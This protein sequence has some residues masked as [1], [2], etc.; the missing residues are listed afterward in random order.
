MILLAVISLLV[1]AVLAQRFKIMVL[2]PATAIVIVAAAYRLVDYFD[3]RRG[4]RE[5]ADWL[6]HR[7]WDP[8]CP[9]RGSFVGSVAIIQV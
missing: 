2:A 7:A 9:R 5:H 6:H 3:C 4:G 8:L 1:G